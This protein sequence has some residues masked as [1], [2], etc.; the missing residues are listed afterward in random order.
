MQNAVIVHGGFAVC[1]LSR[2]EHPVL[3]FGGPRER[4]L[5]INIQS[6]IS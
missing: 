4:H 1:W 5:N 6:F 2:Y 3:A